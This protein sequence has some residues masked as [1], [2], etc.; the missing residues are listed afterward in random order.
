MKKFLENEEIANDLK[1]IEKLQQK[2]E[3][4]FLKNK[5]ATP[6]KIDK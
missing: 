3:K 1:Q 4:L 6:D 2:H 5:N